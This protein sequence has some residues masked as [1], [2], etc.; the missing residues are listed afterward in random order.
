LA[1]PD[2]VPVGAIVVLTGKSYKKKVGECATLYI[3]VNENAEGEIFEAFIQAGK[4]GGCQQS[5]C[6]AVGRLS[7]LALRAG[8]GAEEV[9]SQLLGITCHELDAQMDKEK[10]Y[11]SCA[12]A[13]A[14]ILK[15]HYEGGGG[16]VLPDTG[17]PTGPTCP[18]CGGPT[19]REGRCW[20]CISCFGSKCQ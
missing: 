9:I 18:L 7:S 19:I 5:M 8:L 20:T 16:D 12:D 6:E 15:E 10:T 17:I 2:I 13:F 11:L 4:T 3:Q 14:R 1:I